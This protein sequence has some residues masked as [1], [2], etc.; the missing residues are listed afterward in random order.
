LSP[1]GKSQSRRGDKNEQEK[2][3]AKNDVAEFHA[4]RNSRFLFVMSSSFLRSKL[5]RASPTITQPLCQK[6]CYFMPK[7]KR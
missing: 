2:Q 4:G 7:E 3:L 6:L 5:E 1:H